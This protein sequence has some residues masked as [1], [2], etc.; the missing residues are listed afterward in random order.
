MPFESPAKPTLKDIARQTGVSLTA[1]SH[2]LNDRLGKVRVGRERQEQII[3]TAR[4]LGYV[5]QLRG[6]SMVTRKSFAIG[7]VCSFGESEAEMGVTIY[8]AE[9]IRGIEEA[10]RSV[11]YHCLFVSCDLYDPEQFQRP[12]LMRDGSV[13]GAVL[14]G[15]TCPA[16]A[17]RLSSMGLPC[18]QV[19]SNVSP[20]SGIECIEPDLD[21]AFEEMAARLYA[22]GHRWIELLLPA[23][24][25]PQKL[26]EMFARVRQRYAG[27]KTTTT[28]ASSPSVTAD[29]GRDYARQWLGRTDRPTAFL[30]NSCQGQ[31][32]IEELAKAGLDYPKDYSVAIFAANDL[33]QWNWGPNHSAPA[34]I[35][36]P[37]R[38]VGS[39]AAARLFELLGVKSDELPSWRSKI[40]CGFQDRPSWG[41]PP[42]GKACQLELERSRL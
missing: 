7:A 17:E 11:N 30:C 2:V 38:K 19:G 12:R 21:A 4:Q 16:V 15:Y 5:P 18:V 20:S 25:G 29:Q 3:Q 22:C 36:L 6:R 37:V 32:L 26:A 27:L 1:V 23:G 14:V 35:T 28:F 41:P 42:R 33:T 13:D 8:F 31:G 24:P 9:A 34:Q 40:A 39:Q 10:C